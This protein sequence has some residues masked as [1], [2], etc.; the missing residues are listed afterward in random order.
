MSI[1]D[2]EDVEH[3]L[4]YIA[5]KVTKRKVGAPL[6]DLVLRVWRQAKDGV[7]DIPNYRTTTKDGRILKSSTS[8][9]RDAKGKVIG[10]FCINIDT[11]EFQNSIYL[12]QEYIENDT[13]FD[14]QNSETFASTVGET[15]EAIVN[16]AIAKIGKQ[17]S[18]MSQNE[19][20]KFV[21]VIE[22]DG[23]FLIKGTVDYVAS[24]LG[25]SKFTVYNYLQ[26]ARS[27]NI[28]SSPEIDQESR[29]SG[30]KEAHHPVLEKI[31]SGEEPE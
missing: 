2:F 7:K 24:R 3:S 4:I 16:R 20:V 17:P 5:G 10:A 11:T 27:D 22:D 25:V 23:A 19:K 1:H 15:I 21:E 29:L 14:E 30:Q 28:F 13:A 31:Q 6:T 9:I 18:T 12:L 8:F 26:K